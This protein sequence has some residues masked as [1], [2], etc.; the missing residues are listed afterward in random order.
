MSKKQ[1][2]KIVNFI[3]TY[4]LTCPHSSYEDCQKCVRKWVKNFIEKSE[5]E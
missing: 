2:D 4:P 3:M 1:I 5:K